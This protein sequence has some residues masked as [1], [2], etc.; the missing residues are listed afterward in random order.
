MINEWLTF[1]LILLG[2]WAVIFL[3]G[4]KSR[5]EMLWASFLT[6]PFGL[7]E[8]IFVPEY[9]SPP[10]LFNL[11]LR[12]GFDIESFIFSFAIGGIG[13]ILYEIFFKT[14]HY[15]MKN[16]LI[17]AGRHKFY[18]MALLSGPIIFIILFL[19][20]NLNPIYSASIA[21]FTGAISAI[22]CRPDLKKKTLVGGVLFT[23]LYF[24][25]FLAFNT[26]YPYAVEQFWNLSAISGILVIGVPLEEII[27]AFAFGMM[28]SGVYEHI[29]GY[30][31]K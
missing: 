2:I 16:K 1:S 29:K 3:I 25:F 21:M 31:I 15:K 4:K 11:A 6:M 5:K 8:P 13:V 7:V 17:H 24:I 14:R 26:I 12:T 19:G 30:K 9:W 23:G 20:T 27:F 10:S 28:W 22:L 18:L